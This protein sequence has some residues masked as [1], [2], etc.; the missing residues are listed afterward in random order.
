[1]LITRLHELLIGLLLPFCS[2][3]GGYCL[4]HFP[5]IYGTLLFKFK[6]SSETTLPS[7]SLQRRTLRYYYVNL[8]MG[9]ALNRLTW[10]MF[11][12]RMSQLQLLW[13]S[14]WNMINVQWNSCKRFL[15]QNSHHECIC[16]LSTSPNTSKM[17]TIL[18]W[19]SPCPQIICSKIPQIG[20]QWWRQR[21]DIFV[22]SWWFTVFRFI[23][24]VYRDIEK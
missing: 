6:R 12:V 21:Q 22:A 4:F 23:K 20:V 24:Y 11:S 16:Y 2:N 18:F 8:R 19:P 1:M 9:C 7:I 15:D 10:S 17:V 3:A 5:N 14:L 13:T